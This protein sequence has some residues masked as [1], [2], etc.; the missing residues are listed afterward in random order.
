MVSAPVREPSPAG[1]AHCTSSTT[2]SCGPVKRAADSGE[3]RVREVRVLEP[4][5]E[6]S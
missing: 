5:T 2:V 6:T 1:S 4:V 3:G